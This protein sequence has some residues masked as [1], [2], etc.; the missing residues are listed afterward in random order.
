MCS[1][2]AQIIT[3]H[4]R[5]DVFVN[6]TATFRSIEAVTCFRRHVIS[7]VIISATF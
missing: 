5:H 7:Y 3:E 6:N 4:A 2:C 1:D